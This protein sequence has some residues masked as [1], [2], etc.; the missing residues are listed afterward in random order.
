MTGLVGLQRLWLDP[1]AIADGRIQPL[2]GLTGLLALRCSLRLFTTEQYAWMR[3]HLGDQV[4]SDALDGIIRMRH[5][6]GENDVMVAGKRKPFLNSIA[7]AA[8]VAKY[9]AAY[10]LLVATF[11]AD[12]D[13]EP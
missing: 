12:P 2:A 7:Q 1:K 6:L 10:A 4:R 5:S 9:E 8:R 13:L 11:R 3:A